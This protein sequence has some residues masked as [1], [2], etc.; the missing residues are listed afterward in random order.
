MRPL[1]LAAGLLLAASGRAEDVTPSSSSVRSRADAHFLVGF[2]YFRSAR[3]EDARREWTVCRE[4]DATHDFCEFG[5]S[6]LDAGAPKAEA[7][8][9]SEARPA[10]EA[11]GK[12]PAMLKDAPEKK[13]EHA[14]LQAYFTG[15]IY[16]QKGDFVQSRLEWNR[17][18]ALAPEGS[19]V[20]A[21]VKAALEK[22]DKDEASTRGDSKK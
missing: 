6:V 16:Y 5:L 18:R 19:S 8:P 14:A 21:D 15:L 2:D 10:P 3:P 11:P 1:L 7:A 20:E 9:A 22:L 12:A 13:D 17:T 4:L